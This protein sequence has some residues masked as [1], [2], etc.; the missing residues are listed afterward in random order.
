M[1]P[2]AQSHPPWHSSNLHNIFPKFGD[3]WCE[4]VA[5]MPRILHNTHDGIVPVLSLP[6]V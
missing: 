3:R 2:N 6:V 4:D 1:V 5:R